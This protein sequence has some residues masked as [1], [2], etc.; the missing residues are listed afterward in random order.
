MSILSAGA[1]AL[2]ASGAARATVW[3]NSLRSIEVSGK[4]KGCRSRRGSGSLESLSIDLGGLGLGRGQHFVEDL[5]RAPH[6]LHGPDGDT[7]VGP[8]RWERSSHLDAFLGAGVLEVIDWH[9]HVDEREVRLRVGRLVASVGEPLQR[10]RP[11]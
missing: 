9:R 6:L 7:A 1:W 2:L 8:E 5:D 10:E 11:R 3:R 4:D